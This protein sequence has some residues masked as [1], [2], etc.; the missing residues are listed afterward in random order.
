ML[1]ITNQFVILKKINHKTS[2]VEGIKM[3]LGSYDFG[4]DVK[5]DCNNYKRIEVYIH[6][7]AHW[8]LTKNTLFGILNFLVKQISDEPKM[9]KLCGIAKVLRDASE[10]TNECYAMCNELI[11]VESQRPELYDLFYE[12]SKQDQ[13]YLR[14]QFEELEFLMNLKLE[15]SKKSNLIDRIF[16]LVM[17]IDVTKHIDASCWESDKQMLHF[18][19]SECRECYPDLRLKRVLQ[20][21]K[22]MVVLGQCADVTDEEI[23]AKSNIIVDAWTTNNVISLLEKLTEQFK[24]N[25]IST[26]LL[27]KNIDNL[28]KNEIQ[29]GYD[30]ERENNS[31]RQF[32]EAILPDCLTQNYV[33]D[34]LENNMTLINEKTISVATIYDYGEHTLLELTD[35]LHG[36]RYSVSSKKKDVANNQWSGECEIVFYFDDVRIVK[37]YWKRVLNRRIFFQLK[38]RYSEFKNY[39][40]PYTADSNYI[41][42]Y[43]LNHGVFFIFV[44]GTDDDI[45]FTCQSMINLDYVREDIAAGYYQKVDFDDSDCMDGIFCRTPDEWRTFYNIVLYASEVKCGSGSQQ[46]FLNNLMLY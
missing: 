7:M 43:R 45:F 9:E 8:G 19:L 44:A 40:A 2:G 32:N 6:E 20:T 46:E 26:S 36:R 37:D 1:K 28:L 42:L 21:L 23:I 13:Y 18:L 12:K 24:Q 27:K 31:E 4:D 34:R 14:Y 16:A 15:P 5:I 41:F 35:T 38:N 11:F 29:L 10:R 22:E 33:L 39:I 3:L 25:N 17:N 30:L